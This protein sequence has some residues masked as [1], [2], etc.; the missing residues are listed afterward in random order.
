MNKDLEKAKK[1]VIE[2]IEH[3][4]S[5]YPDMKLVEHN[6]V[7]RDRY[8]AYK[9]ETTLEMSLELLFIHKGVK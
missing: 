7:D 4:F 9:Q 2:H 6:L 5:K 1:L 3:W 8:D